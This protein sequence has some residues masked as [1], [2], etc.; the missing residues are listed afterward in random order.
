MSVERSQSADNAANARLQES[1]KTRE[2]ERPPPPRENVDR[3][4]EVL[5]QAGQAGREAREEFQAARQ[6]Q[7][8][9]PHGAGAD[10]G[11]RVEAVGARREEGAD[12]GQQTLEGAEVLAMMQAQS[13]LRDGAAAPPV[14]PPPVNA[15]AFAELVERHVRQLAVGGGAGRDAAD[16]QV[17]LRMSDAT[18]PGTDLLLSR[19][20]TGWA[21]KADTR[22]RGSYDAIREAAPELARR[23]AEKGLGRLEIDSE[24]H[25]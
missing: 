15:N 4:R 22:S 19:T 11:Q 8:G 3:F 23:F 12:A 5:R 13:A 18:L 7:S 17:L 9:A 24:L 25:A 6:E 20:E 10:D 21:L 2:G 14:A 16:G 1:A